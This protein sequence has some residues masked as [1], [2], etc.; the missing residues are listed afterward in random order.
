MG[1]FTD[2]VSEQAKIRNDL[3]FMYSNTQFNTDRTVNRPIIANK[4]TGVKKEPSSFKV[5]LSNLSAD[6]NARSCDKRVLCSERHTLA[7]HIHNGIARSLEHGEKESSKKSITSKCTQVCGEKHD[8][9]KF[10][11][12]LVLEFIKLVGLNML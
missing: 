3:G 9:G 4:K 10:S 12:K 1:V 7:M 6:H 2:F 11:A 8:S 5:P